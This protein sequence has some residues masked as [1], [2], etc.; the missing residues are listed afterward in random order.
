MYKTVVY[1]S[2]KMTIQITCG[3]PTYTEQLYVVVYNVHVLLSIYM[4]ML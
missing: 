2:I 3:E 4:Y 1:K